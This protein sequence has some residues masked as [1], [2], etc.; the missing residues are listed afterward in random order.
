MPIASTK[1]FLQSSSKLEKKHPSLSSLPTSK[2]PNQKAKKPNPQTTTKKKK[3]KRKKK[4]IMSE[5]DLNF[6]LLR[7]TATQALR[8]AGITSARPSV[9]DAVT[10]MISRYL[11]LLGNTTRAIAERANRTDAELCDVRMALEDVGLLR[12]LVIF[13]RGAE[14]GVGVGVGQEG[15]EE[16]EERLRREVEDCAAVDA[17]VEWFRGPQAAEMRRVAGMDATAGAK[18]EEWAGGMLIFAPRSCKGGRR[19]LLV[20]AVG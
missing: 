16:E 9:V 13:G 17:L 20:E 8:S 7:I 4:K 5:A 3:K 15:E 10:D 11:V 18:G 2:T 6:A 1:R 19:T 12:P 14:V